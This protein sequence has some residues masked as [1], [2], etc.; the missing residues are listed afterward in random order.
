MADPN[1]FK[2]PSLETRAQLLDAAANEILVHGYQAAS[3]ARILLDAGLTKGAL[4]HYFR[5]KQ[6]LGYAV[7]D[8]RFAPG[9]TETWI[10][11]LKGQPNDP[12]ARMIAL[13]SAA[14]RE[15]TAGAL[16]LGC[17][18]NNLAQEMSP[19]D[20]GFRTRIERLLSEWRETIDQALQQGI[21]SGRVRGDVDTGSAS[22]FIVAA[23]EGCVGAAKASQSR[24]LLMSCGK[25]LIDYLQ[26]MRPAREE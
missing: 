17:P 14:G 4:Y 15:M 9:L 6:A 11:P 21:V 7:F 19:I 10:K 22:T 13:I 3:L 24:T 16:Q 12:V 1:R 26:S 5:N 2:Q 20:E 18:V 23:L 8:E 25:G